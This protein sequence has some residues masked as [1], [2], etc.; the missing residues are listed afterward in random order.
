MTRVA[1]VVLNWNSWQDT[2]ECLESVFRC[3]YPDYRV[4]IVD[5]GS[6]DGSV[7]RILAWTDGTSA[8]I[9]AQGCLQKFVTPPV[10]K[11][12]QCRVID[13]R[14]AEQEQA[15]ISSPLL[16]ITAGGNLG[17]AGGNNVALRY[18]A[19]Q[20]DWRYVWLLNNDTVIS[21]D[22]LQ[23]LVRRLDESPAAGMCGSLL[24]YYDRPDIIWAQGGGSLNRWLAKSACIG[25]GLPLG[26]GYSRADVERL[27]KYVAWASLLVTRQFIEEIG[28]M[29]EEYFLYYEEPDWAFRGKHHFGL[30]YAPESVVYHKVGM[31]TLK[32]TQPD[33][34]IDRPEDYIF[35]NSLRF[36]LKFSPWAFPLVFVRVAFNRVRAWLVSL[37][38]KS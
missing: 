28:L 26:Q 36:T 32:G 23:A 1:I 27:M 9:S 35:R 18:L 14:T 20:D 7:E 6:T 22:A 5:N 24:P 4:I 11:P 30:V 3:D 31:C 34:S 29:S 33:S 38:Q 21:P 13:R 10:P 16:I 19:R 37:L 8:A 17:F 12:V 15:A 2:L 25:N